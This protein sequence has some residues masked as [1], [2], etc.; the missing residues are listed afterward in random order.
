MVPFLMTLN[1]LAKYSM[2]RSIARPLCDSW[3]CSYC[4]CSCF[5]FCCCFSSFHYYFFMFYGV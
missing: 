3:A 5:C 2:T 1:D 4:S